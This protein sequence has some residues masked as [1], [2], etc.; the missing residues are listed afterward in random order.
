MQ[1]LEVKLPDP[2][3]GADSTR[4]ICRSARPRLIE[5]VDERCQQFDVRSKSLTKKAD[6]AFES[7]R[8]PPDGTRVMLDRRHTVVACAYPYSRCFR[9]SSRPAA[10]WPSDVCPHRSRSGRAFADRRRRRRPQEVLGGRGEPDARSQGAEDATLAPSARTRRGR[11][12][13]SGARESRERVACATSTAAAPSSTPRFVAARPEP[14]RPGSRRSRTSARCGPRSVR[15]RAQAHGT[16]SALM[17][18]Q[19]PLMVRLLVLK[20]SPPDDEVIS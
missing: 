8:P 20:L 1:I 14:R 12:A 11:P 15:A 5:L 18:A 17:S 9:H 3:D 2:L 7:G 19:P 16:T 10:F 6:A 13:G 4:Q